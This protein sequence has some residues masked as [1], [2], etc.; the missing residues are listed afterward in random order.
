MFKEGLHEMKMWFQAEAIP[1]DLTTPSDPTE[2][3]EKQPRLSST[4]QLLPTFAQGKETQCSWLQEEDWKTQ[5]FD[6]E[7]V[8]ILKA[9]REALAVGIWTN[10]LTLVCLSF[11][12]S[13]MELY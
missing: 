9:S 5:R 4:A 7:N 3:H 11:L 2:S 1:A 10:F 8:H 13:E 12:I 6:Q